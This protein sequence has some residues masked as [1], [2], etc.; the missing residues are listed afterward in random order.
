MLAEFVRIEN[1][2]GKGPYNT[3]HNVRSIF[4]HNSCNG[5]PSPHDDD[6]GYGP[7]D[8]RIFGFVSVNA[9]CEWFTEEELV[10]LENNGFEIVSV[11]A[12]S[13]TAIYGKSGQACFYR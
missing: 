4:T 12:E 6:M 13:D 2:E 5:H 9:M 3:Y 1:T 8:G 10:E 7:F 11:I